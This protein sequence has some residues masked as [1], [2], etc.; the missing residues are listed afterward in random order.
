MRAWLKNLLSKLS[1]RTNKEPKLIMYI[2]DSFTTFIVLKKNERLN[3]NSP[4]FIEIIYKKT[5]SNNYLGIVNLLFFQPTQILLKIKKLAQKFKIKKTNNSLFIKTSEI[6]EYIT[7]SKVLSNKDNTYFTQTYR[8]LDK[9]IYYQASIPWPFYIQTYIINLYT[10]YFFSN[11][12]TYS[13]ALISVIKEKKL[14]NLKYL[15][16][17]TLNL[18]LKYYKCKKAKE[19]SF[20]KHFI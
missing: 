19:L 8:L 11:F 6:K 14:L 1:R 12:T 10:N 18:I 16:A 17:Q 4:D 13:M 2:T 20:I 3:S 9:K 15:N 7:S 5:Y